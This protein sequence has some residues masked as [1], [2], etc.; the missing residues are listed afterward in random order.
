MNDFINEILESTNDFFA[1]RP[2]ILPMA[3]MALV[4]LNLLLHLILGSDIWLTSSN[5]FLHIGLI[6]SIMGLMLVRVFRE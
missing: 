4:L 6:M 5:L 2:G 1:E 3:G